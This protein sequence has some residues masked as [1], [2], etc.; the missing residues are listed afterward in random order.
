LR[1][2]V[3]ADERRRVWGIRGEVVVVVG[4]RAGVG[5]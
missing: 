5:R 1:G 4:W 2:V 3:E